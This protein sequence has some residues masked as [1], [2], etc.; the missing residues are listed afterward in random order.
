MNCGDKLKVWLGAASETDVRVLHQE[1]DNARI[2]LIPAITSQMLVDNCILGE[3]TI[4][5][6]KAIES[7][8]RSMP[9]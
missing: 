7:Q 5:T 3:K 4:P 2:K 1:T 8:K 6:M 9:C